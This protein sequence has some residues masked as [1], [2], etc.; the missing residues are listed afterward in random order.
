M[1]TGKAIVTLGYVFLSLQHAKTKVENKL[2]NL[3]SQ[4]LFYVRLEMKSLFSKRASDISSKFFLTKL[5]SISRTSVWLE[6][7][8]FHIDLIFSYI[9]LDRYNFYPVKLVNF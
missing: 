1:E 4:L 6:I 5:K 7:D 2:T 9:T 8:G 3:P